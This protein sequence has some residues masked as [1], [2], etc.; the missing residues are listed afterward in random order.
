[1]QNR[2]EVTLCKMAKDDLFNAKRLGLTRPDAGPIKKVITNI[3]M[4]YAKD[5]KEMVT[6]PTAIATHHDTLVAP[7]TVQLLGGPLTE[8][9]IVRVSDAVATA[10]VVTMRSL[11]AL[12]VAIRGH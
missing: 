7:F 1:M 9:A 2:F 3:S 4:F 8:D 11:I 6:G 12:V 10:I 5:F